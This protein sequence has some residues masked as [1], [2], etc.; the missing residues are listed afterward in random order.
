MRLAKALLILL[1]LLAG[2]A[3]AV[4]LTAAA[5]GTAA[6]TA[7]TPL[8]P[9]V[10]STRPALLTGWL[11]LAAA[12]VAALPPIANRI[13]AL[14]RRIESLS[15]STRRRVTI[16]I[17]AVATLYLAGTAWLQ[18]RDLFPR[19][20]DEQSYTIGARMLAR[21]R[22]W[23]PQHPLADF[24]ESFHIFVRPVYA[25]IYFPGTALMNVPGSWFGLPSWVVPVLAAGL[26]VALTYRV[27]AE[28][29]DDP[30]GLLAALM[31]ICVGRFRVLSTMVMA[32]VPAALLGLL[33]V[34]AWLHWR[35]DR[36]A[37]WALLI[38]AFAG[39][40]AITRPV[41]AAAFAVP[42][43]LAMLLDSSGSGPRY[44]GGGLGRGFRRRESKPPPHPSPG[45][46]GAGDDAAT[47]LLWS[48]LIR[49]TIALLAGAAPFLTLQLIFDLGVTGRPF[50]TPYVQYLE[51]NQP[52]STFG[53]V[54]AP[55]MAQSAS[56]TPVGSAPRTS[57][58]ASEQTVC[59][60]DPTKPLPQKQAYFYWLVQ[61]EQARRQAGWRPWLGERLAVTGANALPSALF[62][63]LVPVGLL[64]LIKIRPPR[65]STSSRSG[66]GSVPP[67]HA[68]TT[69]NR[70]WVLAAPIPLFFGL[71]L[72][73]PFFLPHY[74]IPL[75][76]P[77]AF[78]AALGIHVILTWARGDP[79]NASP[80]PTA[81]F[82]W[83]NM[84]TA[85][86]LAAF[87][88][89][90]VRSLHELN[91]DI[92][93]EAYA[94]P[95]VTLAQGPLREAVHAP[96]VILFRYRPGLSPDDEPVYNS[97]VAW[98]DDAAVV[99]AHDLG[100]RNAELF[101]YYA[102]RQPARRFYLFDRGDNAL[103]D[104]GTAQQALRPEVLQGQLGQPIRKFGSGEPGR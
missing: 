5:P 1:L 20:H 100:Q 54:P 13:A 89:L 94:L 96:A 37:R 11:A 92:S 65:H 62:L 21:G 26:V 63:T 95:T 47:G 34:W 28:L 88:V 80:K 98:P 32:Q 67:K 30:A 48:N 14:T 7:P 97:D 57:L 60:A 85:A 12:A 15:P 61:D 76:A 86:L 45:V 53:S 75:V 25:S 23:M 104:L 3:L 66:P 22:L 69:S 4:W 73:N 58:P 6:E 52:G 31:V 10:P 19:L 29:V 8:T 71:Y 50:K 74:P 18:A 68:E 27:T 49:L 36:R 43:G 78:L 46:P 39:W 91:P 17:W 24:F 42:V 90:C 72:F 99:R 44:S 93:D 40:A 33:L 81:A 9:L 70:R 41:D 59:S 83:R 87:V 102:D 79:P 84:A 77:L 82:R 56:A 51:Q 103:Y 55:Q 38:G 101:R 35:K 2:A 16:I 64:G